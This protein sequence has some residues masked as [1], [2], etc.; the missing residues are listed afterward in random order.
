MEEASISS[1]I[2]GGVLT[3]KITGEIDHHGARFLRERIDEEIFFYRTPKI[4]IDLSEISFMD[5][6][7]LGLLLGRYTKAKDIGCALTVKDP[8][9]EIMRILALAGADKL[10]PIE[11]S[12][13]GKTH[14]KTDTKQTAGSA[15]Q[16]KQEKKNLSDSVLVN[17]EMPKPSA[18]KGKIR[19]KGFSLKEENE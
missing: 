12:D 14:K 6:S 8:T 5:S 19:V 13:K 3:F 15:D 1:D 17:N 2:S 18:Y 9:K 16:E 11:I 10:I 7:G 4:I